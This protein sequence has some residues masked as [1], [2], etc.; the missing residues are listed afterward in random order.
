MKILSLLGTA[1]C[2]VALALGADFY[3]W[4]WDHV[5]VSEWLGY[6]RYY[7][8]GLVLSAVVLAFRLLS[9]IRY[10]HHNQ[11]IRFS[12]LRAVFMALGAWLMF[13][14]YLGARHDSGFILNN[15]W[16][17]VAFGV[18]P[19]AAFFLVVL[20]YLEYVGATAPS[21][22]SQRARTGIRIASFVNRDEPARS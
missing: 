10:Y 6:D 20:C 12:R 18:L 13:K 11:P 21:A 8:Y 22:N 15:F 4:S 16:R 14:T 9:E 5:P 3:F 1:F 7:M 19:E 2:A 17:F